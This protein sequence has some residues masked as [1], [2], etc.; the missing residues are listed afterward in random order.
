MADWVRV[1]MRGMVPRPQAVATTCW[2]NCYG[3]LYQW[4]GQD[5]ATI[6]PKLQAGGI[7]V[8]TSFS[9]GLDRSDFMKAAKAIGLK[10]WGAGQSWTAV[11]F[12]TC[13]SARSGSPARGGHPRRMSWS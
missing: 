11:E 5:L 12:K 2:L 3:M 6:G 13:R 8:A 7:D 9:Q 4:N 10:P 1:Q